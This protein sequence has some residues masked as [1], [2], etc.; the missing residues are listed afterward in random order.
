VLTLCIESA[1][2]S[3]YDPRSKNHGM[4]TESTPSVGGS[5][6]AALLLLHWEGCT[7]ERRKN[8][9][10]RVCGLLGQLDNQG[11]SKKGTLEGARR[12]GCK[13]RDAPPP[14]K[15]DRIRFTNPSTKCN[16]SATFNISKVGHLHFNGDANGKGGHV[17]ACINGRKVR[18]KHSSPLIHLYTYTPLH[19][20]T[21]IITHISY[22]PPPSVVPA[23]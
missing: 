10:D 12:G 15:Q 20:Y 16:C 17:P 11:W 13:N 8:L 3:R 23:S 21:Y 6:L 1:I 7:E 19:L 22:F 2:R 9:G 18:A 4:P 14:Q 5:D